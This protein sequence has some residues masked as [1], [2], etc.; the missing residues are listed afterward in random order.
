MTGVEVPRRVHAAT[1]FTWLLA[2]VGLLLIVDGLWELHW[3]GSPSAVRLVAVLAE[4]KDRFG[5]EPPSLLRGRT[6]AVELIVLGA[7]AVAWALLAPLVRKGRRWARSWGFVLGIAAL[8]VGLAFIGADASQP[9]DLKSYLDGLAQGTSAARVPEIKSL[10]YP[11]W[12]AWLEDIAQG[13]QVLA[14]AAAVAALSV[15]VIWHSDYFTSKR[16]ETAGPDEWDDAISRI[17]KRT[18]RNGD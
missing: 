17:H 7:V 16:A 4:I 14:S 2:P 10:V 9:Q 1:V 11:G 15:A 8:V 3:W 5:A 6:G 13:L 12:F 18:V